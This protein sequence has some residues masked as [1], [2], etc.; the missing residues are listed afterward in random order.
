MCNFCNFWVNFIID[1]DKK[2]LLKFA[3]LQSEAGQKLLDEFGL[4]KSDFDT[5]ILID[6]ESYYTRST[7]ALKIVKDISCPLKI[8][9]VFIFLPEFCRDWIYRLV[10]KNR[11]RL[12]GVRDACRVPNEVER[13]KFL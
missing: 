5:F 1:R 7:A 9:S 4:A 8:M 6:G 3:A 2:D 10:A 12:F 13:R 11:Y